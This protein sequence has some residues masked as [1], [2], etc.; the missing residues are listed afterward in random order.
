[1]PKGRSREVRGHT[2]ANSVAWQNSAGETTNAGRRPLCSRRVRGSKSV[3]TRSPAAGA[4]GI[5]SLD[6]FTALIGT[7]IES[8]A[9]FLRR[10]AP[11]QLGQHITRLRRRDNDAVALGRQLGPRPLPPTRP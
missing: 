6:N 5:G 1:M 3:Q 11:L 7:P 10:D 4:F 9:H 2:T 8:L